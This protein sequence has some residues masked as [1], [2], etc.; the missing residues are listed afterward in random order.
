M[1]VKTGQIHGK[2]FDWTHQMSASDPRRAFKQVV[3][4]QFDCI[5]SE[6]INRQMFPKSRKTRGK[7]LE[8]S[9]PI[10]SMPF[11]HSSRILSSNTIR[12]EKSIKQSHSTWSFQR[13]NVASYQMYNKKRSIVVW[14]NLD[15]SMKCN[16]IQIA[17]SNTFIKQ[18]V[19]EQ[20]TW[21]FGRS[22]F[23]NCRKT[24]ENIQW[25]WLPNSSFN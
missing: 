18:N 17:A 7:Q 25:K 23:A 4:S 22:N 14:S 1:A 5:K 10:K 16:A 12:I 8:K 3:L 11:R 24:F 6:T 21:R 13:S 9:T 2:L 19:E 20:R 15:E